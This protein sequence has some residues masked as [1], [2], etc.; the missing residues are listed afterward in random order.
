MLN[1]DEIN[2]LV[3]RIVERMDPAQIIVFGSYAKGKA[4][5][6]SDLDL[7]V[8]TDTHLPMDLRATE[9]LPILAQMLVHVDI[10]VYTPEE[11]LVLGQEKYTFVHSIQR[12]GVIVYDRDAGLIRESASGDPVHS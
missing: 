3:E 8:V 6:K 11:M 12:S 2:Q 7:C 10:H 1:R 4:T 5:N 9:V